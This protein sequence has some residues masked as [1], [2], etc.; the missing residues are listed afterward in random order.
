MH[1]SE[2]A[3]VGPDGRGNKVAVAGVRDRETGKIRAAVVPD[4]EATTLRGFVTRCRRPAAALR[5]SHDPRP[6]PRGG[7]HLQRNSR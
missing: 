6:R 5:G 4:T 7:R 2:R 1:R 3:M